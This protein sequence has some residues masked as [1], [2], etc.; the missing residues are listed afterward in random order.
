M[1]VCACIPS[2][3]LVIRISPPQM[4]TNPSSA[5]SEFSACMPSV[6]LVMVIFPSAIR[7][8][9]LL[10]IPF[11]AADMMYV[12]LVILTSSFAAIPLPVS[13]D[14]SSEPPPLKVISSFAKTAP[15]ILASSD[16]EYSPADASLFTLPSDVVTNTL[17][18]FFTYS[19]ALPEQ[20]TDAPSRTICTFSPSASTTI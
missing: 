16:E 9:S 18:A 5:L 2:S 19:A 8:L 15:S 17:S 11:F 20:V 7:T 1:L 6:P 10:S 14:I 3:P 13:D 12:P 4:Y